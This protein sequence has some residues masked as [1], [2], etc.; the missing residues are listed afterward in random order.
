MRSMLFVA[1]LVGCSTS[2][3]NG[4][5]TATTN[6]W[7]MDAPA[8]M[9]ED[10][11]S[12]AQLEQNRY[13]VDA[14]VAD[15][16]FVNA[17]G[18]PTTPT[19]TRDAT[20]TLRVMGAAPGHDV[21]FL[22]GPLRTD[23]SG[24]LDPACPDEIAPLCMDVDFR[25]GRFLG[26]S[27]ADAGGV[28]TLDVTIPDA[29]VVSTIA[30]APHAAHTQ[31]LQP[32]MGPSFSG[33]SAARTA[34]AETNVCDPSLETYLATL[35][36]PS[37]CDATAT[38]VDGLLFATSCGDNNCD[39]PQPDVSCGE[40]CADIDI[41]GATCDVCSAGLCETFTCVDGAFDADG[42]ASNGCESSCAA[43]DLDECGVCGGDGPPAVLNGTCTACSDSSTCTAL[44]CNT[45]FLEFTGFCIED[46]C[47]AGDEVMCGVGGTCTHIFGT[48][49]EENFF[50]CACAEGY[51]GGGLGEACVDLS[52]CSEDN[53]TV[54]DE[55][56]TAGDEASCLFLTDSDGDSVSD[57]LDLCAG[58]DDANPNACTPD[59]IL[60]AD[61]LGAAWSNTSWSATV[62][63]DGTTTIF[64]GDHAIEAT[65]ERWG[66]VSLS[67][68]DIDTSGYDALS[69]WIHGGDNDGLVLRVSL[70]PGEFNTYDEDRY[71]KVGTDDEA[72]FIAGAAITSS[73]SQVVIPLETL[74]VYDA[75]NEGSHIVSRLK[76]Q[77]SSAD[78]DAP[79]FL[80]DIR[81][82][83]SPPSEIIV[84]IDPTLVERTIPDT[85]FGTNSAMWTNN[86]DEDTAFVAL[87]AELNTSVLR[88]PGGSR[89]DFYDYLR[90]EMEWTADYAWSA[91]P[92]SPTPS[93]RWTT[94]PSE[95]YALAQQ[96]G[97]D[98]MYTANFG[99]AGLETSDGADDQGAERA[100]AIVS[101]LNVAKGHNVKYWE[102]GNEINGSWE[103][104]WTHNPYEYMNGD[105]EHDGANAYCEQM[106]AVDPD[107]LVGFVGTRTA[108]LY[109]GA[110]IGDP[111]YPDTYTP[112]LWPPVL[113]GD[114]EEYG[115]M[116]IVIH[117]ASDCFDFVSVHHYPFGEDAVD[118]TVLPDVHGSWHEAELLVTSSWE[119]I[120]RQ[121]NAMVDGSG[122]DVALTEY[123]GFHSMTQRQS[124]RAVNMLYLGESL[125]RIMASG[126]IYA[127]QWDLE[128]GSMSENG[129]NHGMLI[130]TC[131]IRAFDE[132]TEPAGCEAGPGEDKWTR[133]PSYFMMPLW[134]MAGDELVAHTSNEHANR[135]ATFATRH[136]DTGDVTL[137]AF[138]KTGASQ[139]ITARVSGVTD[140]AM[141]TTYVAHGASI[142]ADRVFY[143]GDPEPPAV[144]SEVAPL[145][146]VCDAN[147]CALTLSPWSM[148]AITIPLD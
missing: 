7:G 138:N 36:T 126:A 64:E 27:T 87:T 116:P 114:V 63:L 100:A 3:T 81:L 6:T 22:M 15:L 117:E 86:A 109:S 94:N 59:L 88:Y 58:T 101:D 104:S 53:L 52:E 76:M 143:N 148:S 68:Y 43:A 41:T 38:C 133:Q 42:G 146:T 37:T 60:F 74:G 11:P 61:Q 93:D 29:D 70:V 119:G 33:A 144:L 78:T 89:S 77:R 16:T 123:N 19:Y 2:N 112:E 92:D 1:L 128:N 28:A 46:I 127:N 45:G 121:V 66:A 82:V 108:A 25:H 96:V 17:D 129:G 49:P 85:L 24:A 30:N 113:V 71:P 75:M 40:A 137:I 48:S 8:W 141:A 39:A 56:C 107:I 20:T 131:R 97:A 135:L 72:E 111:S 142:D 18:G 21:F 110:P 130:E 50:S 140:G 54:C 9:M 31:A 125:G 98:L 12:S 69:F 122:L 47:D 139:T 51:G 120:F 134:R 79:F 35:D 57:A 10:A 136:S 23:D 62:V 105:A 132:G 73:W 14:G 26:R 115:W 103:E 84:D 65:V 124:V 67:H 95:M 106:K 55:A 147:A 102:V 5:S 145:E 80:D 34:A 13:A 91:P 99:S 4:D 90:Y 44:T 32:A 83:A 118:P